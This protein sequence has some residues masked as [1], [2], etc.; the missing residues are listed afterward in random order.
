MSD[1][2]LKLLCSI[3][4]LPPSKLHFFSD[5]RVLWLFESCYCPPVCWWKQTNVTILYFSN[6]SNIPSIAVKFIIWMKVW[7]F[8]RY[9]HRHFLIFVRM[10]VAISIIKGSQVV[11]PL[12][13]G[14][15]EDGNIV[16]L[17]LA[18]LSQRL[19]V[20]L[21]KKKYSSGLF[22]KFTLFEKSSR[23]FNFAKWYF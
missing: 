4:F 23:K 16:L 13:S 20:N 8:Y 3:G 14:S 18:W 7:A 12:F 2:Q 11:E 19:Y 15:T 6:Y 17:L 5:F 22:F 9:W 1:I 10:I 21:K